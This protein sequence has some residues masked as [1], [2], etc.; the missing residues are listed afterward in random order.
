MP[1]KALWHNSFRAGTFVLFLQVPMCDCGE[2][3]ATEPYQCDKPAG[4]AG[5]TLEVWNVQ[6]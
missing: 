3:L 2:Q 6:R 5:I 4:S 1:E